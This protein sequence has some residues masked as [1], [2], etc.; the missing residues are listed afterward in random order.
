MFGRKDKE[1]VVSNL[2]VLRIIIII[3]GALLVVR[4]FENIAHPLTL[5]FVSFFLALAL[6]PIVSAVSR[7]LKSNSR[8]RA[9]AIAYVSVITVLV[10]FFSFIVPPLVEQTTNFVD[11][12][13][14][15]LQNLKEDQ[16]AVGNFVRSYELE[17]QIS[18]FANNWATDFSSN[19]DQ[20]VSLANRIVAN[21]ISIVTVL[22]LTFMMLI[23]GPLWMAAFWR[24]YPKS[25][26]A[27]AKKIVS[28]MYEI[29]TGYVNGQVLVAAIGAAFSIV[30]LFITTTIFDASGVNAVALGGIVFLFSL[31]PMF[32][33]TIAAAIVVLFSLFASVPLAVTMAVYFIIYQQVENATIQPYIQSRVN[34]LTPMLV[35]IAAILGVGFGGVLGAFVAIPLFGCAK[36]LVDDYLSRKEAQG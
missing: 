11:D 32:G 1:L 21:L 25:K 14:Q 31:I 29:V 15:T 36:V 6:N 34:E 5:I 22:V 19:S 9:T 28:K 17:E 2:T 23:E 8:T 27:H 26:R 13:P 18:E 35:F 4:F 24:Q 20:A 33:A 16:G 30:T 7:R 10:A 12:V 3:F